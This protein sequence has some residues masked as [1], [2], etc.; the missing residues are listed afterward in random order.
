MVVRRVRFVVPSVASLYCMLF[1]SFP[2]CPEDQCRYF[3]RTLRLMMYVLFLYI[4]L[5]T[6]HYSFRNKSFMKYTNGFLLS[7]IDLCLLIYS[8]VILVC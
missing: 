5:L 1:P 7:F 8:H 4:A 6:S 3:V 2:T